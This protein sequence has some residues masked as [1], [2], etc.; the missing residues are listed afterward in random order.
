MKN[1]GATKIRGAFGAWLVLSGVTA[2]MGCSAATAPEQENGVSRA[3]QNLYLADTQVWTDNNNVVPVCWSTN[4]YTL[5][6]QRMRD[7]ITNAWQ[8]ESGLTFTWRDACP[9]SGSTRYL[10]IA[11]T[12]QAKDPNGN[13]PNDGADGVSE[14]GMA[15][16]FRLPNEPSSM[17]LQFRPDHLAGLGRTEYIGVHEMG[18]ALGFKHEMDRPENEGGIHCPANVQTDF[19]GLIEGSYDQDSVMSYCNTRGNV[20]G[21]LTE[22]DKLGVQ[23][24]Y[25]RPGSQILGMAGDGRLWH[26]F[27]KSTATWASFGDP[28]SIAGDVGKVGDVAMQYTKKGLTHVLVTNTTGGLYHTIRYPDA[29]DGFGS[30]PDFAPGSS[31]V[32]NHVSAADDN[33]NLHVMASTT[34]GHLWHTIRRENGSWETFQDVELKA[35]ERGSYSSI[36]I[37]SV[38]GTLHTCAVTSDGHLWH[39]QRFADGTWASFADVESVVGETGTFTDVDCQSLSGN[40]HLVGIT[41]DGKAWHTIRYAN[42]WQSWGDVK[43]AASN[44]GNATRVALSQFRGELQ[45]TLLVAETPYNAIR[46]SNSWTPFTSVKSQAGDVGAFRTIAMD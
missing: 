46:H 36:G 32:F 37:A 28:E 34:D 13:Y 14:V 27:R 4:G 20:S 22:W 10:K 19:S 42:S 12:A 2:L 29:W 18:H 3:D 6:K 23:Q 16:S 43:A 21:A 25:A 39:T 45:V 7:A 31:G 11:I 30:V 35:G 8:A 26:S 24:V 41:S 44:P 38:F 1:L 40:L 9:N 5:E 17:N 15:A 33:G